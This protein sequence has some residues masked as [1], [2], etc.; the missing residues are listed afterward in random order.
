MTLNVISLGAGRQSTAM[1]RMAAEGLITPMPDAAIFADTGDEPSWVYETVQHLQQS[2]SIPFPIIVVKRGNLGDDLLAGEDEARIPAFVKPTGMAGRQCTRNYKIRPIRWAIRDLL[3]VG[4]RGYIAPGAVSQWIGISRDEAHRMKPSVV[5]FMVNRWPLIEVGLS[6]RDCENWL[7]A[8]GYPV[9][10]SSACTQCPFVD[11]AFRRRV[12]DYDP[13]GWAKACR[14]DADLRSPA[15]VKRFRG[16]LF[17]HPSRVPLAE[18]DLTDLFD[19]GETSGFGN[20]C[21]GICGV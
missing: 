11:A 21:E 1:L 15:N 16:E 20:E 4:R 13:G 17:V 7:V 14:F 9:P 18:A 12:R 8:G 6:V 19:S 3:G 5:K 2:N 10:W